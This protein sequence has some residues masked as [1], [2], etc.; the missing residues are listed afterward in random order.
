M[1]RITPQYNQLTSSD[2]KLSVIV[3]KAIDELIISYFDPTDG[4]NHL[5][6]KQEL[7]FKFY[8][9]NRYTYT[10]RDVH[11]PRNSNILCIFKPQGSKTKPA[12]GRSEEYS[13]SSSRLTETLFLKRTT[14][15]NFSMKC[16]SKF[17]S[18]PFSFS[19][20]GEEI[21]TCLITP[22]AI[23]TY[24]RNPSISSI[25][26]YFKKGEVLPSL[27]PCRIA[28]R[29]EGPSIEKSHGYFQIFAFYEAEALRNEIVMYFLGNLLSRCAYEMGK[30]ILPWLFNVET[31]GLNQPNVEREFLSN[32]ILVGDKGEIFKRKEF[33]NVLMV[34]PFLPSIARLISYRVEQG[35][36]NGIEQYIQGVIGWGDVSTCGVNKIK[37]LISPHSEISL[38]N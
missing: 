16:L 22:P 33:L 8:F 27:I 28:I 38:L 23:K 18:F 25:L 15:R 24:F 11:K 3:F 36:V 9:R 13:N 32:V 1:D 19:A 4:N 17:D 14:R 34:I 20:P 26:A 7:F 2:F 10:G 21:N 30:G 35:K 29:P 12:F 37:V 6:N 31:S 5:L